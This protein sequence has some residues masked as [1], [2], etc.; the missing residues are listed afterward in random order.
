[1]SKE[2]AIVP[3]SA[4]DQLAATRHDVTGADLAAMGVTDTPE[5]RRAVAAEISDADRRA[6]RKERSKIRTCATLLS[7]DIEVGTVAVPEDADG[8]WYRRALMARYAKMYGR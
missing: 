6:L 7:I 1:M 8:H 3:Y 5:N 2:H 4:M